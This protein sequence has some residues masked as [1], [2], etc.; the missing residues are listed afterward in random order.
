MIIISLV[1]AFNRALLAKTCWHPSVSG[2]SPESCPSAAWGPTWPS[3]GWR[4]WTCWTSRRA[5]RYR[6]GESRPGTGSG[7]RRRWGRGRTCCS[8]GSCR[9]LRC[10]TSVEGC[11]LCDASRNTCVMSLPVVSAECFLM[12]NVL[13]PIIDIH[14]LLLNLNTDWVNVNVKCRPRPL[15]WACYEYLWFIYSRYISDVSLTSHLTRLPRDVP[16]CGLSE[17]LV[18][19][20]VLTQCRL[21]LRAALHHGD[22]HPVT[23]PG[24]QC[25]QNI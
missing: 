9:R 10:G 23:P 7:E 15:S 16:G 20:S 21:E 1:K 8:H 18:N 19:I 5:A 17:C 2:D 4:C 6:P 25:G 13:S 14:G 3:P 22:C 24:L 11:M 12:V